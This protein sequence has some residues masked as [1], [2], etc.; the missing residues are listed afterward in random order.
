MRW[1]CIKWQKAVDPCAIRVIIEFAAKRGIQEKSLC[2]AFLSEGRDIMKT[3]G[4]VFTILSALL[5]GV[6]PVLASYTYDMG[7]NAQTLT[8]YRNLMVL[9]VAG[10]V[11][12]V[13]R[14]GFRMT[15]KQLLSLLP[16]GLMGAATTLILYDSYQYV[17]IGVA[18]TLHFLYPVF[19]ALICR[20]VFREKLG[21]VK[22]LALLGAT[23]GILCFMGNLQNAAWIGLV[24]ASASG[25]TYAIYLAGLDKL[26][27]KEMDPFLLAFYMAA[28]GALLML[29]YNIPTGQIVFALPSMALALTFLVSLCTSFVGLMLLQL[30]VKYLNAT[31]AAIFCLFEPVASSICGVLFL[32]EAF[33]VAKLIGSVIILV[34]A[35]A[36]SAAE[37]SPGGLELHRK[38]E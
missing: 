20:V 36:L 17:G 37:K 33:S 23:V 14:T 34:A 6:T 30:G 26:K 28:L 16:V 7:S 8:F 35:G 31:T 25:L 24:L 3:K 12:L 5:Y 27:L 18:T 9:P 21:R 4:M 29:L 13:R 22:L 32:G 19:V 1:C 38:M 2:A 11:L 15:K 10:I